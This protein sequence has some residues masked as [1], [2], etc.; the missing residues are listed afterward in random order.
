MNT[1]MKWLLGASAV[2]AGIFAYLRW[3]NSTGI[4][5]SAV[6]ALPLPSAPGPQTSFV[7]YQ[8][9]DGT[10]VD[11]E[12]QADAWLA[13]SSQAAMNKQIAQGN[14]AAPPPLVV[15]RAPPILATPTPVL[16]LKFYRSR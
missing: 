6:V 14:A 12:Q 16:R 13:A 10:W 11:T 1:S 3:R 15:S 9:P 4:V 2:G 7:P 5:Q 8:E